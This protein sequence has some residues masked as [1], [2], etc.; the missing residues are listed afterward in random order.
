MSRVIF[1]IDMDAFFSQIEE[2]A[3]P[4]LKGKPLIVCGN[5]HSRSVVSTASYEARK[6]GVTSGMAV[7]I[8][9]RLCPQGVYVEGNPQKYI[10]TS[11]RILKLLKEF[12]S[13][14]E[15][16][17]VDEAFLEFDDLSPEEA[18]RVAREIKRRIKKQFNLTGSVGIG[19]NK[20]VAKMASG[21]NKP[22]GLTVIDEGRFLALFGDKE[23][24]ELWGVGE[25]TKW[26]LNRMGIMK[27]RDLAC[28]P[29]KK[30]K[31]VFGVY[32]RDLKSVANG[33]DNTPVVPYSEGVEPKSMG[34]EYTLNDDVSDPAVLLSTLLMLTEKVARRLRREGYLGDTITVKIR[35]SGFETITRQ[36]KLEHHVNRDDIIYNA[37]KRLFEDNHKGR[38]LRLLGVSVSGLVKIREAY[39]GPIFNVD[40]KYDRLIETFDSIR[41]KFGEK[42]IRRCAGIRSRHPSHH[43]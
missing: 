21:M 42:S 2:L 39:T 29:E 13:M 5:P 9:K 22:D 30:L 27:I 10:Y 17:S 33:I 20:F 35:D 3:N 7:G 11:V 12:T 23:V 25:K 6:Y 26:K 32:G 31:A 38:A 36:R 40:R 15:P 19:P 34:H 43:G 37:A 14:V 18:L 24:S 8:A 28:F 4:N 1:H 16:F 41:N